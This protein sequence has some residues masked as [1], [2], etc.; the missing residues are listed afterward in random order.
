MTRAFDEGVVGGTLGLALVAL[1]NAVLTLVPG[2]SAARE[3]MPLLAA[4]LTLFLACL[5]AAGGIA[6]VRL[7]AARPPGGPDGGEV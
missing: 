2:V 5:G 1:G 3:T 4:G 6:L 7:L